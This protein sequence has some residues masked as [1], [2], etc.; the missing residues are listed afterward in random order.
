M[1]GEQR[2]WNL[3]HM[4]VYVCYS[5]ITVHVIN[6]GGNSG[7]TTHILTVHV[8]NAGTEMKYTY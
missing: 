6:A 4:C 1:L 5:N 8:I 7:N 3:L 2:K